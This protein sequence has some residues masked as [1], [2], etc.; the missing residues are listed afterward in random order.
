MKG[1]GAERKVSDEEFERN[2]STV[3]VAV[4]HIGGK[5][6]SNFSLLEMLRTRFPGK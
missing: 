4:S 2:H 6:I 3:L 5:K 1:W